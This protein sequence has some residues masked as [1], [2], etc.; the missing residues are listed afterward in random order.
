ML[1][2]NEKNKPLNIF[3]IKEEHLDFIKSKNIPFSDLRNLLYY[4]I[5]REDL[6][7]Y[8]SYQRSKEKQL[9]GRTFTSY[10]LTPPLA[11]SDKKP[12]FDMDVFKEKLNRVYEE[13]KYYEDYNFYS[14]FLENNTLVILN[15]NDT[16]LDNNFKAG[17]SNALE[18]IYSSILKHLGYHQ[19]YFN[20]IVRNKDDKGVTLPELIFKLTNS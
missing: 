9:F 19:F 20:D 18:T 11:L 12:N 13:V 17:Q 5:A 14:Y 16:V 3:F 2:F 8:I 7:S 10:D 4:N 6:L 1:F 15:K